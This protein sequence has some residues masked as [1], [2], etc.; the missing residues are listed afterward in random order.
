MKYVFLSII[1]SL[2]C[3][4]QV[5][6]DLSDEEQKIQQELVEKYGNKSQLQQSELKS[7]VEILVSNISSDISALKTKF[8][9]IKYNLKNIDVP[10]HVRQGLVENDKN[11]QKFEE[12]LKIIDNDLSYQNSDTLLLAHKE[13]LTTLKNELDA[14][15]KEI[16]KA[17]SESSDN[18]DIK[19]LESQLNNFPKEIMGNTEMSEELEDNIMTKYM[20]DAM[21][22]AL[23]Q[24]KNDNPFSK[25]SKAEVRTFVE[26]SSKMSPVGSVL[27]KY[28]ILLDIFAEVFHDEKALPKLVTL[29]EQKKKMRNFFFVSLTLFILSIV[30]NS[31]NSKAGFLKRFFR[32]IL[33]TLGM[34]GINLTVFYFMFT[35]EVGPAFKAVLRVLL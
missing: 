21:K 26:N 3:F 35:E 24:F 19:E 7:T 9:S 31:L 28:P 11:I 33:I 23:V 10:N 30:L 29:V 14:Y 16:D 4:A 12:R 6:D 5:R 13:S 20:D 25:M 18:I 15:V 27:Q 2:T 17:A 1:I 34:L 22:A 32:K 8:N